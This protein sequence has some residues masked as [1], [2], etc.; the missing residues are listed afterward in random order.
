MNISFVPKV[1][2]ILGRWW[3]GGGAEKISPYLICG[4]SLIF[5]INLLLFPVN[6][7]EY[8]YNWAIFSFYNNSVA[9]NDREKM[10][11]FSFCLFKKQK[12]IIILKPVFYEICFLNI[13][14]RT[15]SK[16]TIKFCFFNIQMKKL[17]ASIF[18]WNFNKLPIKTVSNIFLYCY[19]QLGYG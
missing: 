8:C 5:F 16:M 14:R 4:W 19:Q 11:I 6:Y 13:S 2:E 1:Y 17:T 10:L 7:Q 3:R 18:F 15:G 9:N 12:L